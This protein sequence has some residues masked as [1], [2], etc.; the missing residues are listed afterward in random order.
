MVPSLGKLYHHKIKIQK[1]KETSQPVEIL[2]QIKKKHEQ[3]IQEDKIT[4]DQLI[5]K[6]ITLFKYH[7]KNK[8]IENIYRRVG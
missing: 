2:D 3:Y 7:K 4:D 6:I 5:G 8:R 1:L